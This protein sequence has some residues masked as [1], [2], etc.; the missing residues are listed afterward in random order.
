MVD[1]FYAIINYG[2][3]HTGN[4][5]CRIG[6]GYTRCPYNGACI[7]SDEICDGM[8]N[9]INGSD[10]A[11]CCELCCTIRYSLGANTKYLSQ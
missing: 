10:E 9:C 6:F 1:H 4:T 8:N 2:F 11:N 5:K 3:Y 7:P